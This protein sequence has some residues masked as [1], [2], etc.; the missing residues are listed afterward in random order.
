MVAPQLV[1]IN[2]V[3][4]DVPSAQA[5]VL[6]ILRAPSRSLLNGAQVSLAGSPGPPMP[7]LYAASGQTNAPVPMTPKPRVS[8]AY[9]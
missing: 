1:I 9:L 4:G 3:A 8:Y 7:L 6:Q 5:V 2:I